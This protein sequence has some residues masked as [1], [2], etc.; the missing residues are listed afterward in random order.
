MFAHVDKNP[1]SST[2]GPG[3]CGQYGRSNKNTAISGEEV[4]KNIGTKTQPE[5]AGQHVDE[6]A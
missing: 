4:Y 2:R 6:D 5:Q 1:S 3:L